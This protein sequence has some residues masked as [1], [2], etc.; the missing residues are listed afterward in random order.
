M[1]KEQIIVVRGRLD[2]AKITG[3]A[4]PYTGNPKYDK[5]P[6]WSLDITPDTASRA[7]IKAAGIEKKLREPK[8]EKDT[9]TETFLTLKHLRN[10]KDGKVNKPPVIVNIQGQPWGDELIGNGTIADVM[11]KVKDYGSGSEMGAYLQKTRI[12]DH[13]PYGGADF[14]EVSED[15]EFFS[16]AVEADR[17]SNGETLKVDTKG[18]APESDELDDDIPF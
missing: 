1:S 7:K 14:E 18:E 8:G 5:G 2:W 4:R 15:D 10:G 9:R 16:K 3:D 17:G 13:V 6:Y 11:I 12:L